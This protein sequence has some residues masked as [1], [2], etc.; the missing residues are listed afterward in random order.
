MDVKEL[1]KRLDRK[2]ERQDGLLEYYKDIDNSTLTEREERILYKGM[3]AGSAS[4]YSMA[5]MIIEGMIE[6]DRTR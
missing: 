2:C 5:I 4:A 3:H 1:I 6:N